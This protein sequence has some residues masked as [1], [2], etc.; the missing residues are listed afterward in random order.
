L[1]SGQSW[2]AIK[3]AIN[4]IFIFK[5]TKSLWAEIKTQPNQILAINAQFLKQRLK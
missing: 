5:N 4:L 2:L 1:S 3:T